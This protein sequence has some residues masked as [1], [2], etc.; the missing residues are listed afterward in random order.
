V[1]LM[2]I[3]VHIDRLVLKGFGASDRNALATGIE[4]EFTR[5]FSAPGVAEQFARRD[6]AARFAREAVSVEKS[7]SAHRMGVR[8]VRGIVA[9][10]R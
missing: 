4:R 7:A 1:F 10:E 6:T 5:Q 8:A 2:R 9:G 3:R